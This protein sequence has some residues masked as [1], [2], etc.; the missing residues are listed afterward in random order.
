M[1]TAVVTLIGIGV[2]LVYFIYKWLKAER[3]LNT[4]K[5]LLQNGWRHPLSVDG[6]VH[7][8]VKD[9]QWPVCSTQEALEITAASN[10]TMHEIEEAQ[11]NQSATHREEQLAFKN[12]CLKSEIH[13][14]NEAQRQKN[15]ALDAMYYV[16]CSG[17]CDSGARRWLPNDVNEEIVKAA[18]VNTARLR[19]WW[20]MYKRKQA[21]KAKRS[22]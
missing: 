10:W 21:R 11:R 15:I 8:L 20:E 2:W 22:G 14:Q 9:R 17:G 19:T 12:Q 18:E 5:H 4:Y 1:K 6:W 7:P 13:R 16:W 3:E